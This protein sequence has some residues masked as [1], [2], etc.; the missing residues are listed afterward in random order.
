MTSDRKY[1]RPL[2]TTTLFIAVFLAAALIIAGLKNGSSMGTGNTAYAA[3]ADASGPLRALFESQQWL[4]T[5]PLR[6]QDIRGKVVL[7]NFW[8]Y[9][10]INCLRILPH[11]RAWAE[12]YKS[13]GLIV[14]GV[15]TPEFAFEKDVG[16]VSKASVSLGVSYPIAIDND[17]G[18]WR[19]FDNVVWPAL[20]F[21]GEDGRIRRHVFG[22]GEYDQS[23]QLI[24][25]LLSEGDSASIASG[26]VTV[27]GISIEAA[28]DERDLRSLE[29]YI[30][31]AQATN[32]ASP[33]L[34][35]KNV[36]R[37]YKTLSALP[38]NHWSLAGVWTIAGENA[39]LNDAPGGIAYR[40][41]A[42]DLHLVLA[43]SSQGHPIRFRVTIDGNPP[44]AEHGYDI[45]ADGWGTLEDD[46]LYQLVRQAGKVVDLTFE[47][48]F[49]ESGVR[50]YAFTFG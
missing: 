24:Q 8:T 49:F 9:S 13:R 5:Q 11:V 41:H 25:Q 21:I 38:F 16:N 3:G 47:I 42:R 44:G 40:F 1:R 36:S 14:I 4:N 22:E 28:P 34:V 12:K 19:A 26:T 48:K 10:C 39:V 29:T 17:F 15:H 46:R 6:A 27:N 33:G 35:S 30:G 23:E 20:Y 31:Y 7:V 50:A 18:I 43:R 45:D 37:V 32:F 2:F